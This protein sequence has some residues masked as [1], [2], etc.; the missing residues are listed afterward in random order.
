[1]QSPREPRTI[2][3]FKTAL[4]RLNVRLPSAKSSLAVYKQLWL[5][6]APASGHGASPAKRKRGQSPEDTLR[7]PPARQRTSPAIASQAYAV[8]APR[9]AVTPPRHASRQ[10]SPEPMPPPP[11]PPSRQQ[12]P[13]ARSPA[14]G[15]LSSFPAHTAR[16]PPH[17][18]S[19]Q[20]QW[21]SAWP[22]PQSQ[23]R[24]SCAAGSPSAPLHS[25]E[26]AEP[27]EP[28]AALWVLR[29]MGACCVVG[30]V[31]IV[32]AAIVDAT[33]PLH[34][35]LN[36]L[37]ATAGETSRSALV[38]ASRSVF[39]LVAWVLTWLVRL[40]LAVAVELL[41][42]L[43]EATGVSALLCGL[44]RHFA[45]AGAAAGGLAGAVRAGAGAV[46]AR[47]AGLAARAAALALALAIGWR[48]HV[49]VRRRQAQRRQAQEEARHEAMLIAP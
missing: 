44:A 38:A 19:S 42:V 37:L 32:L 7:G 34:A 41:T 4:L 28:A 6:H 39:L 11:P 3:E 12:Q 36:E 9:R 31:A 43:G 2:A 48:V 13:A 10:P 35:S 8:Q 40:L 26:P 21:P 14:L 1:M 27:A 5:L 33:H 20:Q 17:G 18:P 30:T 23:S 49:G 46:S 22:S 47:A 25:A 24:P 15:T 29:S 16:Q 45:G